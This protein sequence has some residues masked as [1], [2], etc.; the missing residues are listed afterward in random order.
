MIGLKRGTVTLVPYQ[1]KWSEDAE[2]IIS[3]LKHLLG[4][5]AIDI[6]HVGSTAVYLIHAKPIIDISV[7]VRDLNDILPHIE[8]LKQNDIIFRGEVIEGEFLFVMGN[9]EIL[10]WY[11]KS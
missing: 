6:Q 10:V 2:K 1:E 5:T 4:D 3:L 9:D 11:K 8:V 7:A